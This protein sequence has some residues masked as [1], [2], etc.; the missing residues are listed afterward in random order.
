MELI[1]LNKSEELFAGMISHKANVVPVVLKRVEEKL[2]VLKECKAR[3]EIENWTQGYEANFHR[4]LDQKS[5][6]IKFFDRKMVLSK[7]SL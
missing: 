1:Y 7:S 4:S 3:Y 2:E 5:L 6:S